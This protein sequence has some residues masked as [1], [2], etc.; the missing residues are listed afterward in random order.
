MIFARK[1]ISY[2]HCHILETYNLLNFDNFRYF[3]FAC[4]VYKILHRLAPQTW[5]LT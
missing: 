3:K 5:Y 1:P 2:C 4:A